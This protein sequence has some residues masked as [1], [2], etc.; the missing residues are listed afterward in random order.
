MTTSG[1]VHTRLI[2][3]EREVV[4][5][6]VERS[7]AFLDTWSVIKDDRSIKTKIFPK[8]I[9]TDQYLHFD[10][11]HPLE[12]K[13][14]VVKTMMH[15]VDTIVSDAGD[16]ESERTH[17]KEALTRNGH[18]DW[19]INSTQPKDTDILDQ[20]SNDTLDPS[21]TQADAT[22]ESGENSTDCAV[23]ASL[24]PPKRKFPVVVPYIRGVAEQL[25]RVFKDYDV[26]AYFKP[27]NTIKQLLVWPK[28]KILN[29]QVVGPVYHIP[30]D[31]CE[32]SYI[33][34]TERSLK[35]RFKDIE[36]HQVDIERVKILAVEPGWFEWGV[37]EAIYIR[38]EQPS[39]NKDGGHYNLPTGIMC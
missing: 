27:S 35:S 30:C 31:T 39:L 14:G 12:H 7:F 6:R 15:R 22:V 1:E 20:T 10:S 17:V 24:N 2:S 19:L 38:T 9:H 25:R 36:D 13:I 33:G 34:E 23:V 37:R 29:E 8:D 28:D 26:P 4:T 21:V 16:K 11:N 5:E 18:P 3:S 32:S